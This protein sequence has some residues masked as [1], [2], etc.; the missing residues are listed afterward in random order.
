MRGCTG[1]S[2]LRVLVRYPDGQRAV[3]FERAWFSLTW[4]GAGVS[5]T[6]PTHNEI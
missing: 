3:V 5:N 6:V 4:V 1:D 2:P